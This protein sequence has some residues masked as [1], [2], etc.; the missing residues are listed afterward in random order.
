[1]KDE[2]VEKLHKIRKESAEKFDYDID[3]MFEDL[4]NKQKQQAE[5]GR[6]V[7]SFIKEK[8]EDEDGKIAA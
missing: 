5:K 8:S 1:M 4:R 7:I 3:A 6:K 2:I